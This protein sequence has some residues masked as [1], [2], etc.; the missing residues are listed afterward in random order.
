MRVLV[1]G[2][3]GFIGYEVARQL[4]GSGHDVRLLVRRPTRAPLVATF[5]HE[6][7]SGDLGA[8]ASIERAVTGMDAVIHLAGRATFEPY[9]HIAETLVD[10]TAAL[11][12]AAARSGVEHFVFGSSAF[13]YDSG[14]IDSTTATDP[15]LDYG[16]AKVDAETRLDEIAGRTG[17]RVGS[18]RLPHVYG[19][20]SLLFGYVRRRL[21]PFPGDGT[22]RFAQLHVRD[23]A[24]ALIAATEQRWV[25]SQPISDLE[26]PTWNEFFEVLGEYAPRVRVARLPRRLAT[27][28]AGALGAVLSRVGPT[29]VARDTIRGWNLD[30][31]IDPTTIWR[32][33]GI[34][35]AH[36]SVATGIPATLDDVV[37]F[38]WRHPVDDRS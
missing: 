30:I 33:L 27:L 19:A 23:A 20:Q 18:L 7:V 25:G 24:A 26:T 8:P 21:I 34:E 5:G 29:M 13:V 32:D 37:A 9:E 12:E 31:D 28:G 14:V 1:T 16:R 22:N 15:I 36:A 35:P 6:L 11:A 17:M 4:A 10:G 2:A 3:T 38:R